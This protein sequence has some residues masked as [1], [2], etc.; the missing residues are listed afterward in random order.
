MVVDLANLPNMIE[1]VTTAIDRL[2]ESARPYQGLIP[3]ILDRQ[4]GEMLDAMPPAIPGQRDGDRAHLG[5][6][7][8]HDQA[9]LLTMYALAESEGRADYA[10]AA[11]TYLERFATHCTNTPT[12][13]FPWGEH[14]Y[15]HLKNDAIGNSYLLRE[16]GDDPPVTH[17]HLRQAPLW[18]WEKLNGINPESV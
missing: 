10:E 5:A 14:A 4:T 8:I 12:G 1:T 17:D 16:R 2:I 3:S 11:D 7:L 6:N 13:I 9:L 15:W 18:L